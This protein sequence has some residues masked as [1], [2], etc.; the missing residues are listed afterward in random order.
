MDLHR[1]FLELMSQTE[2]QKQ[3]LPTKH[4]LVCLPAVDTVTHV[5]FMSIILSY[6]LL[7]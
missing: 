5:G 2:M 3:T 6:R 7:R 1:S 4:G